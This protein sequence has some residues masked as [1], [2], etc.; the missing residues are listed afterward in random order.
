MLGSFHCS[1]E[2][3]IVHES[4]GD[5]TFTAG[6]VDAGRY[7]GSSG[8]CRVAASAT[9]ALG[10]VFEFIVDANDVNANAN[11]TNDATNTRRKILI[12]CSLLQINGLLVEYIS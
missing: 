2:L 11:T 3:S 12:E 6:R 9:A 1:P 8:E 4:G 5:C 10:E 7:S